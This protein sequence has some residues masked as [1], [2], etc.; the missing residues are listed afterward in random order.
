MT[1]HRTAPPPHRGVLGDVPTA[2]RA[3][4]QIFDPGR[5]RNVFGAFPSGVAAVAALVEDV[6]VGIAASSF[7][8]VSLDPPLVSLCIGHT[9]S[10][11][12]ALRAAPRLGLS[13]LSA[14]QERAAR[15]LAGRQGD[16]FAELRWRVTDDGAVL[17]DGASAWI[18]TS[19]DQQVRAGD[20]D[21]VVLR[22]HDLD[23]DHDISPLVFHASQFR[24]LERWARGITSR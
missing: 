12:P 21:I 2:G 8:S 20:H 17:L 15:Q 11:W 13:I 22:V 4:T 5:L 6:P 7:T 9:S 14:E 1:Y 16:R 19:I 18:E 10:T 23:A 3:A 24:R